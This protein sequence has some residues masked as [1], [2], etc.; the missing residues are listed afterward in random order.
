MARR[1]RGQRDANARADAKPSEDEK[2][3]GKRGTRSR[4]ILVV[5]WLAAIALTLLTSWWARPFAM[6]GP[7]RGIVVIAETPNLVELSTDSAALRYYA[8]RGVTGILVR[9]STIGS[10]AA[11]RDLAIASGLEILRLFRMEGIVN[12]YMWEQIRDRPVRTDATYIFS[13]DLALHENTLASIQ[14][15]LGAEAARPYRDGEHDFGGGIPGNYIIEVLAPIESVRGIG[16]GIAGGM[17]RRFLDA[18]IDPVVEVNTAADVRALPEPVPSLLVTGAGAAEAL[19]EERTPNNIFLAPGIRNPGWNQARLAERALGETF[20][21]TVGALI[22]PLTEAGPVIERLKKSGY[23]VGQ[24]EP[25]GAG[26]SPGNSRKLAAG[27]VLSAVLA[28]VLTR[29]FTPTSPRILGATLLCALAFLLIAPFLFPNVAAVLLIAAAVLEAMSRE[30]RRRED[31]ED[32]GLEFVLLSALIISGIVLA[33]QLAPVGRPPLEP[34]NVILVTLA[35]LAIVPAK[36][37]ATDKH[38]AASEADSPEPA[39]LVGGP[40]NLITGP[41]PFAVLAIAAARPFP[42]GPGAVATLLVAVAATQLLGLLLSGRVFVGALLEASRLVA[43]PAGLTLLLNGNLSASI[44]F[45]IALLLFS[46]LASSRLR[47]TTPLPSG[48]P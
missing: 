5:G 28:W 19:W 36:S 16:V 44:R 38:G 13:N 34:W 4:G 20:T 41:V 1:D 2:S 35:A 14:R 39:T 31:R 43:W 10:L 18:G 46:S 24:S 23:A 42:L 32:K 33:G 6:A 15:E 45:P 37:A 48:M 7:G 17:A 47:R 9:S 22:T 27:V 30:R 3:G 8:D 40:V 21:T 26:K 25:A 11:G 29:L 12:I